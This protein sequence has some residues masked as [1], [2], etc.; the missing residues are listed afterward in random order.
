ML[1]GVPEPYSSGLSILLEATQNHYSKELMSF[2][3]F[4]SVAS[5]TMNEKS[6]IDILCVV[7]GLE[8]SRFRRLG[9]WA[10]MFNNI[11]QQFN[12][13]FNQHGMTAPRVEV[14]LQTPSEADRFK[15]IYLDMVS[16][17]IILF[18]RSSFLDSVLGKTSKLIENRG[19]VRR[20]DGHIFYWDL[21]P[22]RKQLGGLIIEF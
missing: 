13:V 6:D 8:R 15:L 1:D 5:E 22:K 12:Q 20:F 21:D 3:V 18:D 2:A 17:C 14:F 7:D 11:R 19:F 16:D 9:D 10:N 4:G